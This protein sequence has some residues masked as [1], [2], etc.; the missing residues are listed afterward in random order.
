MNWDFIRGGDGGFRFAPLVLRSFLAALCTVLVVF[1]CENVYRSTGSSVELSFTLR[2]D[3]PIGNHWQIFVNTD[4]GNSWRSLPPVFWKHKRPVEQKI[5]IPCRMLKE[6]RFDFGSNPGKVELSRVALKGERRITLRDTVQKNFHQLDG[7]R[8]ADDG[9]TCRSSGNDPHV[10]FRLKKALPGT[11]RWD[12]WALAIIAV[13][14]FIIVFAAARLLSFGGRHAGWLYAVDGVLAALFLI[15]LFLPAGHIGD[16]DFSAAEKRKLAAFRPLISS[17][18]GVNYR[19]G[20]DFD[21]WFNDHFFGRSALLDLN[22]FLF[23]RTKFPLQSCGLVYSGF[24]GWYFFSGD[25]ALRNYHNLDLFSAEELA[26]AAEDLNA[27]HAVCRKKGKK[28]YVVIVPDKHKVY[29]E[30][31]PGAPKIRPDS[32]S[33]SRQLEAYLKKHTSVPV[34]HLLD[35]LL[36]NKEHGPLYWKN[37][38]H[39]NEMGAYVCY[40]EIMKTVRKDFPEVP[41]CRIDGISPEKTTLRGDLNALSNGELIPDNTLYPLPRFAAA[42]KV[43]GDSIGKAFGSSTISNPDGKRRVL[44]LRDSFASSLLPYMGNSFRDIAAL[45]FG[46]RLP[47]GKISVFEKSDIVI[48]ECVERLLPFLLSG[49]H[50][51][52][53]NIERGVR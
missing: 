5:S 50:H 4:E 9:L 28:L 35:T 30:Y 46:Y 10:T 17:D 3:N 43:T 24:D 2:Y 16:Q 14:T 20:R 47:L 32:Q 33:R 53:I 27:I 52:R 15:A 44:I 29:G 37:S 34:I 21:A 19:F 22:A 26:R 1:L 36:A 38:T 48:F 51:S 45:W 13:S 12:G 42:Y 40:L 49:I 6:I 39:W 7:L 25:N 18:R 41:L 11:R 23:Q 31:F 8:M